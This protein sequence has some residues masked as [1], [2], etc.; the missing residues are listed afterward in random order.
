MGKNVSGKILY[1]TESAW[2]KEVTIIYL[3]MKTLQE[4]FK[5]FFKKKTK[6]KALKLSLAILSHCLK[7]WLPFYLTWNSSGSDWWKGFVEIP[8]KIHFAISRILTGPGRH[9]S[10]VRAESVLCV[11]K[12]GS[13]L[14]KLLTMN[15]VVLVLENEELQAVHI[16]LERKS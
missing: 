16:L 15:M 7:T 11:K 2:Q 12:I 4:A 8:Q 10:V 3:V 13:N 9:S 14:G 1:K 5:I 6:S